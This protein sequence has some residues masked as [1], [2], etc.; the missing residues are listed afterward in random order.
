MH[1]RR[2]AVE[3]R[4]ELPAPGP[5]LDGCG[6]RVLRNMHRNVDRTVGRGRMAGTPVWLRLERA[7][8]GVR[9]LCRGNGQDWQLV[10]ETSFPADNPLEIGL[11]AEG[12]VRPEI[13]PRS[14]G[15]GSE[16]VFRELRI[17]AP[18]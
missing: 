2:R 15:A 8:T 16:I 13:Y 9:A 7:N 1:R 12:A 17:S 11:F 14:F 18:A 4:E 5:R 10:G 3:G 6:H